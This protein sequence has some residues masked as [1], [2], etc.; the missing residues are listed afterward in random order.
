MHLIIVAAAVLVG[1]GANKL[2]SGSD[3]KTMEDGA[4]LT[5]AG[6]IVFIVPW[7]WLVAMTAVASTEW[8][9]TNTTVSNP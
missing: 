1:V 7:L 5:K 2:F 8:I 6:V 4:N 9:H 3:A